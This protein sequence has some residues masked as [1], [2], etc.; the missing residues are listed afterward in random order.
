MHIH[1]LLHGSRRYL[2][3]CATETNPMR[4]HKSVAIYEI[5]QES[6]AVTA[7]LFR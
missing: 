5:V 7:A 2:E 6:I 3:V 1:L 4:A